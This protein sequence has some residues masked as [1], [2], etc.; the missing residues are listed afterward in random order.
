MP[1]WFCQGDICEVNFWMIFD[2]F[3]WLF[4][5]GNFCVWSAFLHLTRLNTLVALLG[6]FLP[7]WPL[8]CT[9]ARFGT[10]GRMFGFFC[11]VIP[12][13]FNWFLGAVSACLALHAL[14]GV[15]WFLGAV[16]ACLACRVSCFLRE[17]GVSWRYYPTFK[18]PH[19]ACLACRSQLFFER[20]GSKLEELSGLSN[21]LTLDGFFNF[22]SK[23]VFHFTILQTFV[24]PLKLWRR[25]YPASFFT[26]F[27]CQ[28]IFQAKGMFFLVVWSHI[29]FAICPSIFCL[30]WP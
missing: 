16:A 21:L 11:A 30:F 2:K 1:I 20:E 13:K 22:Q 28:R 10:F 7:I 25:F 14:H 8:F 15:S 23:N 3:S 18:T 26:W 24:T 6:I 27:H 4:S 19:S 29:T 9:F 12:E 5:A 17:R